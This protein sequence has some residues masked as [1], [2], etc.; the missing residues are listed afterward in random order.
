VLRRSLAL[1]LA[2]LCLLAAAPAAAL[3]VKVHVRVEGVTRTIFGGAQPLV[4]PFRGAL[5]AADGSMVELSRPTALGALEAASRKGEFFYALT[6][7]SFGPYVSQIGRYPAAGASG[8]VYKVNGVSPPVGADSY[9]LEDGDVVLWYYA[10]FGDSGGPKTLDLVRAPHRC[11]RA[12]EVDDAGVRTPA[13]RVVFLLDGR[14][15]GDADGMF[16]PTGRWHD[17]RATKAGDVRS[18]VLTRR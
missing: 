8:W 4:S 1:S 6:A 7:A 2:A 11:V 14:K 5:T 15:I 3:A 17:V 13:R 12:F 18:Q 10:S 9:V 16:C